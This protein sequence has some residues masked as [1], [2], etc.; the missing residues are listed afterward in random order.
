VGVKA[1]PRRS[2]G[3]TAAAP[4]DEI[5]APFGAVAV[6]KV[7]AE[8]LGAAILES[9]RRTLEAHRPLVAVETA[10]DVQFEKV[11]AL[12]APLGYEP[13]GRYCWTPTWLWASAT[14]RRP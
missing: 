11:R 14:A 7:D 13:V 12:L 6:V 3:A 9:G 8:G 4:L 5:L 10:T 1:P 2:T